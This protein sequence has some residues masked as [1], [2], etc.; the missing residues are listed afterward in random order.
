MEIETDITRADLIK[1]NL[2]LLPREK[3]NRV[4]VAVLAAG[5]FIYLLISKQPSSLGSLG[6]AVGASI[7]GGIAGL[8]AGF[9]VSLL[10]VSFTSSAKSG[11]LGRHIYRLTEEGLHESTVA[12]EGTQ[13]WQGIQAVGKSRHFI[14]LR[15]NGYLFHFIPRRAFGTEQQFES[16]WVKARDYWQLAQ[17]GASTDARTSRG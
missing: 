12:N 5:I 7:G 17:Q 6:I 14:F 10:F 2:Y 15:I 1:L 8:L 11:V 3:S 13:K 16:F 4:T 9:I